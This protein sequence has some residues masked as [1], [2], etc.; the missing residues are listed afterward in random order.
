MMTKRL[1]KHCFPRGVPL[2][3]RF[4]FLPSTRLFFL[5]IF[6]I[7]EVL[8][9]YGW[10][11]TPC[12]ILFFHEAFDDN[13]IWLCEQFFQWVWTTPYGC[14]SYLPSFDSPPLFSTT[15]WASFHPPSI[16]TASPRW[17][18]TWSTAAQR[19]RGVARRT[20]SRRTIS[21]TRVVGLSGISSGGWRRVGLTYGSWRWDGGRST[22]RGPGRVPP[23]LRPR[24]GRL[25]PGCWRSET[26]GGGWWPGIY[27]EKWKEKWKKR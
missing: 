14:V 4:Y 13:H 16:G 1:C 6:L 12:K 17:R 11:H 10:K 20:R 24:C 18:S 15:S 25:W 26:V 27:M 19:A 21:W 3:M 7:T 2:R 5:G 8:H 23:R 22:G 9:R